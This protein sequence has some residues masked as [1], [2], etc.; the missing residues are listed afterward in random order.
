M[1]SQ[2]HNKANIS[3]RSDQTVARRGSDSPSNFGGDD[4]HERS[5]LSAALFRQN[6]AAPGARAPGRD[7]VS[8]S[9]R[10]E[11][12][13]SPMQQESASGTAQARFSPLPKPEPSDVQQL[14]GHLDAQEAAMLALK[15]LLQ[16]IGR[17]AMEHTR[18]RRLRV[19]MDAATELCQRLDA[20]C[21]LLMERL[22]VS[23][24]MEPGQ[25][26]VRSIS[27]AIR[28]FD[29]ELA[30]ALNHA[31]DRLIR[32][33]R[34][35]HRVAQTTGWLLQSQ[36]QIHRLAF[37]TASGQTDSERYDAS[38]KKAVPPDSLRYGTRS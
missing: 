27:A 3:A 36:T 25:L 17:E 12:V 4:H 13:A 8:G 6:V 24:H 18:D 28:P 29:Q 9:V 37:Q 15:S 20:D 31:R 5:A 32:L 34:Q 2:S 16:D 19:R 21:H 38:G 30:V 10:S 14:L 23:M 35:I 1:P 11:K 26:S 7:A 33:A 22:A